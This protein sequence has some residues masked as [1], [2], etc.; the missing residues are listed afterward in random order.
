MCAL[1]TTRSV[2]VLESGEVD[3]EEDVVGAKDNVTLVLAARKYTAP[4]QRGSA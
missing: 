3:E 1:K 4:S 2:F